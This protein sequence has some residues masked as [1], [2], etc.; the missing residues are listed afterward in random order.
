MCSFTSKLLKVLHHNLSLA[1]HAFRISAPTRAVRNIFFNFG[2]VFEKKLGFGSV[3]K[4][5]V[6]FGYYSYLLLM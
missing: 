4:N 3:Q 2:S 5:S 1:S 6:Q